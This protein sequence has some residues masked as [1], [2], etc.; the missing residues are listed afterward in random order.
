[1]SEAD[2]IAATN[3]AKLRIIAT[4]LR[5][6]FVDG[7]IVDEVSPKEMMRTLD[8]WIEQLEAKVNG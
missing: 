8:Q 2:Y 6:V 1:M 5:S 4:T 3:L 7:K